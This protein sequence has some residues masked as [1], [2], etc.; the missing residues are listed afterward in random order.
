M[1]F[2]LDLRTYL[3]IFDQV[4]ERTGI[5]KLIFYENPISSFL[6][7]DN[8]VDSFH[9]LIAKSQLH[10]MHALKIQIDGNSQK[11]LN[12]AKQRLYMI[13]KCTYQYENNIVK[14]NIEV[15]VQFFFLQ[16][17]ISIICQRLVC[18]S[19]ILSEIASLAVINGTTPCS[20]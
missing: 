6:N 5:L 8:A 20:F 16:N 7:P 3:I 4:D 13:R 12:I 9:F 10:R 17:S 19:V 1:Y 18:A 2:K 11:Y 15:R 14:A